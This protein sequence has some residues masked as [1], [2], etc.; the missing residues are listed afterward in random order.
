MSADAL[1]PATFDDVDWARVTHMTIV[2]FV[3]AGGRL[4]LVPEGDRLTLP[5]GVVRDDED[6]YLDATLRIPLET[7]GFR[8]QFVAVFAASGDRV[9]LWSTG[10]R[11]DGARPHRD[12]EWWVGD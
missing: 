8:K 4:V 6:A 9:A 12:V 5:N 1:H 2:P 3:Q 10:H 7:A 11:Y